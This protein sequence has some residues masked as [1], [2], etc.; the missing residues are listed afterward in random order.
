MLSSL[1]LEYFHDFEEH[2]DKLKLHN[3]ELTV[4]LLKNEPHRGKTNNVV[5]EQVRYKSGCTVT[6]AG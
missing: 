4:H 6:D 1:F 3:L 2:I 5:S